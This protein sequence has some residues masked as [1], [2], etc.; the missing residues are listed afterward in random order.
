MSLEEFWLGSP[1]L[2]I[3]Y[4]RKFDNQQEL[5]YYNIDLASWHIGIYVGR[6]FSNSKENPYP[7]KPDMY[8]QIRKANDEEKLSL[9]EKIAKAQKEAEERIKA[10]FASK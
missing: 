7:N 3:A 9:E 1:L 10:L 6:A 5:L 2:A 8:E 4:R